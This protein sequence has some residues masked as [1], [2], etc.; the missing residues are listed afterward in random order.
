MQTVGVTGRI[1][2]TFG[3]AKTLIGLGASHNR[4]DYSLL[5]SSMVN[6]AQMSIT[7]ATLDYSLRPARALSVEGKSD[8]HFYNQKNQTNPSLSSGSTT[9][10]KHHL[11]LHVFPASRWMLSIKN[12]L[13]H[14]NDK[15]IGTNYFLDFAI[16]YKVK[17]WELSKR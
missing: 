11:N 6:D 9:D 7:T 13:F 10:W 3:W 14:T 17:Q 4:T 16:S 15:S 8:V 5:V 1:S 2:K 12:E